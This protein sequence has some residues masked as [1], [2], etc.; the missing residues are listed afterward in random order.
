MKY[1]ERGALRVSENRKYLKNGDTPFFWLGDTAWLLLQQSSGEDA[2]IYLKNRAD[3]GFNV[4]QAVLINSLPGEE[5]N[6]LTAVNCDVTSAKFWKH[7]DEVISIAEELGI[8]MG[9]LPSWGS[10]VKYGMLNTG[11]AAQYADFLYQRYKDRPNIIW[12]LGGDILG[13]DGLDFYRKFGRLLKEK[14]PDKL[15]AYH[16]FGRTASSMWF[17]QDEWLDIN[18]FQSGH[19]R[20]DQPALGRWDDNSAKEEFF[21]E[22]NWK[23]V[24]RDLRCVP[25][26]PTLDGEPSYEQILQGLHDPSQPYWQAWDVRRYAYW[27]VFQGAAG[28]TYG[29]NAFQQFY[30]GEQPG[31][32]G[33][34]ETW[35]ESIHHEGSCHM[36]HLKDLMT[37]VDFTEGRPAEELLLSGQGKMYERISVFAGEDFIFCYDYLGKEFTLDLT[38]Y[39]GKWLYAYWLDPVSGVYSYLG[40]MTGKKAVTVK[41]VTRFSGHN[42]WVLVLRKYIPK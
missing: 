34:K 5:A 27:S 7:C 40:D 17:Q 22:D 29:D 12:I 37:S 25:V 14:M 39:A 26:K 2:R 35:R 32:Y 19:R 31:K 4:I 24:D 36:K 21:G 16:P 9:L 28:H 41:P 15:I 30:T 23:Y 38:G 42:D 33:V 8:Y 18:M 3:K 1:W 11:N 13:T 20:Y 6:S 10:I